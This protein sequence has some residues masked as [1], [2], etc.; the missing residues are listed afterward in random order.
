[1]ASCSPK[2]RQS[3]AEE[4]NS[5]TAA[6]GLRVRGENKSGA[7]PPCLELS[8][9][10][11]TARNNFWRTELHSFSRQN[12]T[13]PGL[14]TTSQQPFSDRNL[15]HR[16]AAS[17][18]NRDERQGVEDEEAAKELSQTTWGGKQS[19]A[20]KTGELRGAIEGGVALT[21]SCAGQQNLSL[22]IFPV[23]MHRLC[24]FWGDGANHVLFISVQKLA[25][26]QNH[27]RF[28]IAK[29][30]KHT[31]EITCRSRFR[32]KS[33]SPKRDCLSQHPK[34]VLPLSF[35]LLSLKLFAVCANF[36]CG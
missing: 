12:G 30:T 23:P 8:F 33:E 22:C 24:R 29:H 3:T 6:A 13:R 26:D 21:R 27:E 35:V 28:K 7:S 34:V 14:Q 10:F 17:R 5:I 15:P 9:I 2:M 20:E 4:L 19:L 36:F 31:K 18:F 32:S 25:T 16:P 1:M 11:A